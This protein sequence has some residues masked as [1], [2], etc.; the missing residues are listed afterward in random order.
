MFRE[1]ENDTLVAIDRLRWVVKD[2]HT[3][4]TCWT[5]THFGST[6]L[7][8]IQLRARS[9]TYRWWVTMYC[10]DIYFDNFFVRK[11]TD[12]SEH[13]ESLSEE[14]ILRYRVPPN[15]LGFSDVFVLLYNCKLL[16]MK[17]WRRS[18]KKR[19]WLYAMYASLLIRASVQKAYTYWI[20]FTFNSYLV[21]VFFTV[22][23]TTPNLAIRLKRWSARSSWRNPMPSSTIFMFS[24]PQIWHD[25]KERAADLVTECF[26]QDMT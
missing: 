24:F 13:G 12:M 11:R 7:Q 17:S 26:A 23:A 21:F 4:N 14:P 5:W 10:S 3:I 15:L 9:R 20:W 2:H 25:V 22:S 6:S 18:T 8:S 1:R 16:Q 19:L